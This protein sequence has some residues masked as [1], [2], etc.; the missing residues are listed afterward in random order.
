[1]EDLTA[2]ENRGA[3][4]A[5][6]QAGDESA[7]TALVERHRRELQ[8]HCYRMTG[9][10]E[11][12]EDLVQETLLRSWRARR[13]FEGRSSLRSWLYR[14]ATNACL[15]DL[16]RRRRRRPGG[17]TASSPGADARPFEV[18]WLEPYPDELLDELPAPDGRPDAAIEERET[19]ELAFIVAVQ[20]LPPRPRAVL[21]LRDVLGWSAKDTARLLDASVPAVNSALQRARAAMKKH[22]PRHRL[23]WSAGADPSESERELVRAY[24]DATERGDA[25]ALATLMRD[26]LRFAMPPQP[27]TYTGLDTVI[28]SWVQGGFG[29]PEWGQLRCLVTRANRQPAVA[30]YLLRPGESEATA[31]A[32]D[33]LRFE[34]GRIAEVVTFPGEVFR[35]FSLPDVLDAGRGP[36]ARA[37]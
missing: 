23:E 4:V 10:L 2:G 29:K 21:I 30:N 35:A 24:V 5:A 33:L 37:R 9:S 26:D 36:R 31:M 34:E 20:Q 14:I 28:A 1:M 32:L 27:E 25:E 11:D 8:L 19:V 16:A 15:D 17:R 3:V 7:F 18:P 22:L 6:M 13:S 12:S